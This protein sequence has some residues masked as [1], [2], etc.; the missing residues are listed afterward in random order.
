[1]GRFET[2]KL[3]AGTSGSPKGTLT[4][5]E[6]KDTVESAMNHLPKKDSQLK[7]V[8]REAEGHLV[9]TPENRKLIRETANNPANYVGKDKYGNQW[10][11]EIKSDGSQIWATVR[12]GRI[13]NAGKNLTPHTWDDETGYSQ[14][15][16]KNNS[17][18]KKK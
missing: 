16:K 15:P 4:Q 17:W 6:Y 13:Q 1:M 9:D 5:N 18:R 7:H 11:S 2:S 10:Y 8:F 3:G 12:N 14:N